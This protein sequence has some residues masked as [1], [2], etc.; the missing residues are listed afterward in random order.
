MAGSL[1]WVSSWLPALSVGLW[2][3]PRASLSQPL[4][5]RIISGS[6]GHPLKDAPSMAGGRGASAEALSAEL[7]PQKSLGQERSPE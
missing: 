5:A 2:E 1:L 4:K 3:S 7:W 6:A